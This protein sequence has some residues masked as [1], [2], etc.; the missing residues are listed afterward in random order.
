[1]EA[2][3]E[4]PPPPPSKRPSTLLVVGVVVVA[5]FAIA[6]VP[7]VALVGVLAAIAVPNFITMQMKAKRA[8]VPGNVD[9][10][11]VAEMAYDAA[12]DEYVPAGSESDAYDSVSRE[13]RPWE[14]GADWEKIGWSPDG[15]IRGA[16]WVETTATGFEVHGVIDVDGDGAY[17]HYVA[18]ES[19][20]ARQIS[21]P[22]VY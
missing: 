19:T 2:P 8:E 22:D 10:I 4:L 14:G 7:M 11:K 17:A 20:Y 13:P 1:M 5:T 15:P 16:Y 21:E 9:G 6:V 3:H 18:T 12:F